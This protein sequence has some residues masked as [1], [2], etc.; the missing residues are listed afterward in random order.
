M[1]FCLWML[2]PTQKMLH[3]TSLGLKENYSSCTGAKPCVCLSLSGAMAALWRT[4]GN[5]WNFSQPL[6]ASAVAPVAV[7]AVFKPLGLVTGFVPLCPDLEVAS[8]VSWRGCAGPAVLLPWGCLLKLPEN[9]AVGWKAWRGQAV[10]FPLGNQMKVR[11]QQE[12]QEFVQ[13]SHGD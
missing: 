10:L 9:W 5:S 4:G 8:V 13:P 7:P 3:F 2:L 1:D 11:E 6:P 12:T